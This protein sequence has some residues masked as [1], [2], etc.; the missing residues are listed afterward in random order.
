MLHHFVYGFTLFFFFPYKQSYGLQIKNNN[1]NN[2]K[3]NKKPL[4]SP[5]EEP[6]ELCRVSYGFFVLP[7][8]KLVDSQLVQYS[9]VFETSNGIPPADLSSATVSPS[10]LAFIPF[11][12]TEPTEYD[13]PEITNIILSLQSYVIY[14]FGQIV[15]L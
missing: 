15:S 12:C 2:K 4:T 9:G 6:P 11:L 5:P 1:N 10:S 8:I 13:N 3:T 14:S 7:V